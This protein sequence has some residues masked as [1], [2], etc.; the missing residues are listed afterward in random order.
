MYI[1]M[2]IIMI[3][4]AYLQREWF[5]VVLHILIQELHSD[6]MQCLLLERITDIASHEGGF[7]DPSIP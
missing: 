1:T 6:S 7:P 5:M 3:I 2:Y 4:Y